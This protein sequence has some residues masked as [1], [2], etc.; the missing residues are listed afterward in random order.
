MCSHTH[1]QSSV[2]QCPVMQN[3]AQSL[4]FQDFGCKWESFSN[5]GKE[6]PGTCFISNVVALEINSS[7]GALPIRGK[8]DCFKVLQTVCT[9]FLV[10]TYPMLYIP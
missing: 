2:G 9:L 3:L 5:I 6:S 10:F 1:P 4:L 8:P 7:L